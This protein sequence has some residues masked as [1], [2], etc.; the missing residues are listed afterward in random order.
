LLQYLIS[1]AFVACSRQAHELRNAGLIS[2]LH[3]T[4]DGNYE[5]LQCDT[6]SKLCYCVDTKTGKTTGAVLPEKEWKYLPC[7]TLNITAFDRDGEYLRMCES[8]WAS[9]QKL[10]KEANLHGLDV[11]SGRTVT[12][13][14]D[15]SYAQIQNIDGR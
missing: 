12:C 9:V 4:E 6:D 1:I 5:A 8:D 11:L 3:C 7:Y 14:Y 15:G 2:T 10:A 13:D